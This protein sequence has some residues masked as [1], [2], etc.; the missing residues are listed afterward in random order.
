ME[1]VSTKSLLFAY[2]IASAGDIPNEIFS[3]IED[4]VAALETDVGYLTAL[5]PAGAASNAPELDP[6]HLNTV[7]PFEQALIHIGAVKHSLSKA[8]AVSR[9]IALSLSRMH[10]RTLGNLGQQPRSVVRPSAPP[11]DTTHAGLQLTTPSVW[12]SYFYPELL[13]LLPDGMPSDVSKL[14][15]GHPRLWKGRLAGMEMAG[16]M[17]FPTNGAAVVRAWYCYFVGMWMQ[18]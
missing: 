3:Q 7:W 11:I 9:R 5:S 2:R 13:R 12:A 4:S 1:V 6:Y 10:A 16:H 14:W 18:L 17:T 15:P 8:A